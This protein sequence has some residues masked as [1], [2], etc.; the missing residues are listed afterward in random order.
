MQKLTQDEYLEKCKIIHNNK[1]NYSLVKYTN[2]RSN[3]KIICPKHGEFVQKASNHLKWGCSKCTYNNVQYD[4]I[5]Q[6]KLKFNDK[7]D[8]SK[9][10]Y[11]NNRTNVTINCPIH[12]DFKR[13]LWEHVKSPLGCLKCQEIHRDKI[14]IKNICT[15]CKNYLKYEDRIL[16]GSKK[17][18]FHSYCYKKFMREN[19]ILKDY[20]ITFKEYEDMYNKQN[21]KCAICYTYLELINKSTNVDHCHNTLKV[22]GILCTQC[23]KMLG[24]AQDDI[25]I[26]KNA[27]LYLKDENVFR[28]TGNS[29]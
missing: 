10:N 17:L 4:L 12:G 20:G 19:Q 14:K 1:Y 8:Y 3:I 9:V 24:L 13:R 15:Y 29:R 28:A 16:I 25:N 11:V 18:S 5:Q 27:I 26:L 2:I 6:A 21:K 22:R 7:F 23:N